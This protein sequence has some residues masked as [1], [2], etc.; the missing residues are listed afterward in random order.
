MRYGQER[1][2]PL[3]DKEPARV[4][5]EEVKIKLFLA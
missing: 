2:S 3:Q 5:H 1:F 4:G